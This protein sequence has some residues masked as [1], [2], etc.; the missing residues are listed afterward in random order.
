MFAFVI[1]D[2]RDRK[3][4]G[5]RDRFGVK[6]FYFWFSPRGMLAMASEIKQF[7]AVPGWEARLN[8]QAGY[9]FL[10]WGAADDGEQSMF[11]GV[12]QLRG[13][14]CFEGAI[15]DLRGGLPVRDWYRPRPEPVTLGFEEAADRLRE[16]FIDS[17]RL[18][19]RAD[20]PVGTGLSGGLDSSSIVCAVNE[21]LR[22]DES[23]DL[24]N[25]FSAC[26]EFPEF[27]ERPFIEEVVRKT[28]VR[29]RYTFPRIE[30][31]FGELDRMVWHQ[32]EPFHSTSIC[33]E[34]SVFKL[35]GSTPVKVTLE[36]HGADELLA[37]Y[38]N[39]FGTLLGGLLRNHEWRSFVL[40]LRAIGALHGRGA[41]TQLSA[42]VAKAVFP[43]GTVLA[44]RR[45]V[46]RML[47]RGHWLDAAAFGTEER[48]PLDIYRE[49]SKELNGLSEVQLLHTSLPKQLH[50]CDRDSM[51][52]SIESRMPFL[53]YRLVEFILGCPAE[54]KLGQGWTKRILRRA[55]HGLLPERIENR[56]DK[57]GFV[58]SEEAWA[59]Q[60]APREFEAAV[61]RA[62]RDS[63][64]LIDKRATELAARMTRGAVPYNTVLWRIITFG[65]WMRR[66]SVQ[67]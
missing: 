11:T 22:R 2:T 12:R 28:A 33:A 54:Y 9:D 57:M 8:R 30:E 29:S 32:D 5:A 43:L 19:L 31:V 24:Q 21:Q 47:G 23:A 7:S 63:G 39:F 20:V 52:F 48:D 18:R 35:V 37:G 40:E 14:Q 36:G 56:I 60:I 50:W 55:M 45:A 46:E 62:V 10:R 41:I 61:A 15:A 58:T 65:T 38:H 25:T 59:R 1:V 3:V 44:L 26:S 13:G 66:F 53:D 64:G 27:D 16:L 4:F 42:D 51:A 34:W 6:P 67:A 49:R 17:V